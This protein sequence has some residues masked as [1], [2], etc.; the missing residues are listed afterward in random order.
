VTDSSVTWGSDTHYDANGL[1][2][3]VPEPGSLILLGMGLISLWSVWWLKRGWR[4]KR[5]R[6]PARYGHPA[7]DR[8]TA[9]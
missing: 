5:G 9:S 4:K 3:A 2:Q 7:D 8:A 6:M 1:A